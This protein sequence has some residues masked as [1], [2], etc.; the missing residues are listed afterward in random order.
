MLEVPVQNIGTDAAVED[1][2]VA[3]LQAADNNMESV[4]KAAEE[5]IKIED[6]KTLI[7]PEDKEEVA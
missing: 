7:V 5:V 6:E 2:V 4:V 1:I 3:E